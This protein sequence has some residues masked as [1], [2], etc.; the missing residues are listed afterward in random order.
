MARYNKRRIVINDSDYYE[1]LRKRFNSKIIRHYATPRMR[2][3]SVA[4]RTAVKTS[5]HIWSYGDRFYNLADQYYGDVRFWW[6]IAWWNSYPTEAAVS[7]G[8]TLAI[9]LNIEEAL[10]VLRV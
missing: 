2:N 5:T 6:V 7:T 3:P 4:E 8:A 9:P 10:K 1:P